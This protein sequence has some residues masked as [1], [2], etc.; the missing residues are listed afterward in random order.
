MKLTDVVAEMKQVLVDRS[1]PA[2]TRF[3]QV[4][5][6]GAGFVT[7]ALGRTGDKS[8]AAILVHD[9][10]DDLLRF[11]FPPHLARGNAIPVDDNSFAGKTLLAKTPRVWNDVA[12]QPHRDF[13]ERIPDPAVGGPRV[14]QKMIAAPLLAADGSVFGVVEVNRTGDSPTD[15][16]ADFTQ[17]DADNLG[18]CCTA[19]APFLIRTWT[20]ARDDARASS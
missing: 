18:K 5:A 9:H 20:E 7:P 11:A 6:L 12:R 4:L 15:A 14:I 16:G 8:S 3:E 13:F 10:E 17:R 1:R 2:H 19:F